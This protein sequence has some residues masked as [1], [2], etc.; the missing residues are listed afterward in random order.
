MPFGHLCITVP[1]STWEETGKFYDAI[2][3]PLSVTRTHDYPAALGYGETKATTDFWVFKQ[4]DETK[5]LTAGTHF[6]FTA[7]DKSQVDD[8]YAAALK[9]G[10]KD[11]GAPGI[12]EHIAK[13]YYAAFAFDPNGINVEALNRD[14]Q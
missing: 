8:F 13:D 2:L 11:N 3:A 6:A 1:E 4:K 9:A 12:R 7:K 10:G 5:I 14:I